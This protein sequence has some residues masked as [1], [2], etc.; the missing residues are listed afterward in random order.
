MTQ[1]PFINALCASLY[2]AA[3]VAGIFIAPPEA[4]NIPE[5][6]A[7]FIMLSLLV[8]SVLVMGYLFFAEPLQLYLDDKR[9][10]A[11]HLFTKTVFIFAGI[12]L[13]SLLVLLVAF[14]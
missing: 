3:V 9:K 8:L 4:S 6:F 2:I 5:I 12:T 11:I 7:P 10:E 13:V 14:A 1:N